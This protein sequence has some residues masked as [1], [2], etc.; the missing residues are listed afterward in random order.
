MHRGERA[1]VVVRRAT[2][3]HNPLIKD[4]KDMEMEE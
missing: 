3:P 2:H 1:F 4:A